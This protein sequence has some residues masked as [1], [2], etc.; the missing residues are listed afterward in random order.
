MYLI[1]YDNLLHR[2][3]QIEKHLRTIQ[4]HPLP[5]LITKP[6][7]KK[8][9]VYEVVQH[10]EQSHAFYTP[11][12][13]WLMNSLPKTTQTTS[14]AKASWITEFLLNGFTP[15]GG[16]VRFKMKTFG[17]FQPQLSSAT[18]HDLTKVFDQFYTQLKVSETAIIA[19]RELDVKQKKVNSALGPLLRFTL[20]EAVAF[21]IAHDERHFFQ[22]DQVLE[23]FQS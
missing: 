20:P 22:I 1:D 10:I 4:E 18:K 17:P 14:K 11:K 23:Q 5:T 15:K 7:P 9:S 19:C 2:I 8:W 12:F 13:E 21:M 16:K 3:R 6:A